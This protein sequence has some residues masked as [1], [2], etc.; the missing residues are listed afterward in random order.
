M[1]HLIGRTLKID[2][3]PAWGT[4]S[5]ADRKLLDEDGKYTAKIDS[6]LHGKW[7]WYIVGEPD[8]WFW[9]PFDQILP[10]LVLLEGETRDGIP[11]RPP[12]GFATS[13]KRLKRA[14]PVSGHG[15]LSVLP[16]KLALQSPPSK[17]LAEDYSYTAP[18]VAA[19]TSHA[20]PEKKRQRDPSKWKAAQ[21][22]WRPAR[23]QLAV[24]RRACF[25]A[26]CK[27][28]CSQIPFSHKLAAREQ[29]KSEY[30]NGDGV[31]TR[32]RI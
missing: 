5:A 25:S 14:A 21:R 28:N 2:P 15:D 16:D 19:M 13:S 6:F 3:P 20:T 29:L 24:K 26:T 7:R 8:T 32:R 12:E 30:E 11:K 10:N 23:T 18:T 17:F 27:F 1:A 4:P 22:V 31:R 9:H